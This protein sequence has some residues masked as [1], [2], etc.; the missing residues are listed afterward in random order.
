MLDLG[1]VILNW[2]TRDLLRDCLRSVYASAGPLAPAHGLCLVR[3]SYPG[4][5]LCGADTL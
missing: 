5:D 4:L 1:V 3:V 2:N